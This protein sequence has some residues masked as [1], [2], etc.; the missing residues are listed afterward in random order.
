MASS[1]RD[2]EYES[3]NTYWSGGYQHQLAN[4]KPGFQ[5]RCLDFLWKGTWRKNHQFL[6][7][8]LSG[9]QLWQ[10]FHIANHSEMQI[11]PNYSGQVFLLTNQGELQ[12][13]MRIFLNPIFRYLASSCVMARCPGTSCRG[14]KASQ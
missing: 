2:G 1:S 14:E 6:E 7:R 4:P 10:E 11:F 8:C 3:K 12:L 9:D 5:D 13:S